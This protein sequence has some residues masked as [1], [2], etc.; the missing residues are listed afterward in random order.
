MSSERNI[1]I[2][3]I[4]YFDDDSIIEQS[5]VDTVARNGSH[6]LGICLTVSTGY[7]CVNIVLGYQEMRDLVVLWTHKVENSEGLK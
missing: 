7:S 2:S 5:M 4:N 6:D 1:N 3:M